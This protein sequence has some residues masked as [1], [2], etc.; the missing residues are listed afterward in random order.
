MKTWFIFLGWCLTFGAVGACKSFDSTESAAS[1]VELKGVYDSNYILRLAQTEDVSGMY[2]FETCVHTQAAVVEHSC[3]PTFKDAAYETVLFTLTT[4]E[5]PHDMSDQEVEYLNAVSHS[6]DRYH[7]EVRHASADGA[8]MFVAGGGFVF[9]ATIG[10]AIGTLQDLG[11]VVEAH[12]DHV[13]NVLDVM[14]GKKPTKTHYTGIRGMIVYN[15]RVFTQGL[16]LG[17]AGAAFTTVVFVIGMASAEENPAPTNT[18]LLSPENDD[19]AFIMDL[20]SA[21]MSLEDHSEVMSVEKLIKNMATFQHKIWSSSG[22][23]DQQVRT[24]SQYCLPSLNGSSTAVK[25]VCFSV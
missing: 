11:K 6:Y 23:G 8:L 16:K 10:A 9:G 7:A 12:R 14:A 4:M 24:I 5:L 17:I 3:V 25:S 20:P 1:D 19:V 13:D 15:R 21:L 18:N 2:L 22:E